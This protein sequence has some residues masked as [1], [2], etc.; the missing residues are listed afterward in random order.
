MK[1]EE[2]KNLIIDYIDGEIDEAGYKNIKA[3]LDTCASCRKLEQSL[4][5]TVI[6]PIKM[7]ERIDAPEGIW[8][9]ISD[10]IQS[11]SFKWTDA[12]RI[13]KPLLVP[14]V[15]ALT[16]FVVAFFLKKPPITEN[17]LNEYIGEHVEFLSELAENG[18]DSYFALEDIDLG[19]SIEKYLL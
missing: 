10:R 12:L 8:Q 14:V 17:M 19:T 1:C 16:L 2:I 9:R 18:E 7:A 15:V 11:P 4:K 13:K 5:E 3:H 6:D